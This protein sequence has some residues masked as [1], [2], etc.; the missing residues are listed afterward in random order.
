MITGTDTQMAATQSVT[1]TDSQKTTYIYFKMLKN[2][3]NLDTL[4]TKTN[5]TY[6]ETLYPET[7][8]THSKP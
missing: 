3:K 5:K 6:R 1:N 7:T 4:P 8:L 2:A